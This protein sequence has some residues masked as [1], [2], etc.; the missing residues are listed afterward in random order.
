[1]KKISVL[2][3]FF[4]SLILGGTNAYATYDPTTGRW[5]SRDPIGEEGGLNLYNYVSNSPLN[6]IDPLGQNEVIVSGGCNPGWHGWDIGGLKDSGLE[7]PARIV[8]R[9]GVPI[10]HD[11]NWKN[12]IETAENEIT[13]RKSQLKSGEVIE[14]HVEVTS[15]LV[16]S[17]EDEGNDMTYAR[18]IMR[19]A[20]KHGVVLR[21]YSNKENF[22]SNVNTNVRG[23]NRQGLELITRWTYFGHGKPGE[24]M[25]QYNNN[26]NINPGAASL[27]SNDISAGVLAKGAFAENAI[28]I[29][30]GCNS[31]A[32]TGESGSKGGSGQ[33]LRDA[34]TGYFG[35]E[36]YGVNGRTNYQSPGNVQ[37]SDDASWVPGSPPN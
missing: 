24:F 36:F 9:L 31:A 33:S 16:R 25:L 5:L 35:F 19:L 28:G 7:L 22:A 8:R 23:G 11:R 4:I 17:A 2:Y 20:N 3:I 37:P 27:T 15:Y 10:A 18:E 34:W 26:Y 6:K 13:K 21:W 1:M 32:S 30:C 12:F 14:W 29:S